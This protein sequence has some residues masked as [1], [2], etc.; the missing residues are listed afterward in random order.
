M[1][2]NPNHTILLNAKATLFLC[3]ALLTACTDLSDKSDIL[4]SNINPISESSW[5]IGGKIHFEEVGGADYIGLNEINAL[6]KDALKSVLH[7]TKDSGDNNAKILIK[8]QNDY[9]QIDHYTEKSR[10][11]VGEEMHAT[12]LYTSPRGFCDSEALKQLCPVLF[13][14]CK[15]PIAIE[16]VVKK[17]QSIIKPDWRFKIEEIKV[18]ENEKNITFSAILSFESHKNIHLGGQ[19]ISAGLHLT[20]VQCFDPT[21]FNKQTV[22]QCLEILNQRLKGKLIKI[23]NKNGVADLEFGLSGQPWRIRAGQRIELQTK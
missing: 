12:L 10:P 22:Y 20:L 4:K 7:I 16:D 18:Y 6:T 21:I 13:K 8:R 19:Y 3:V 17:Y 15:D 5:K 11:D 2:K 14:N 23:S 9:I 1:L